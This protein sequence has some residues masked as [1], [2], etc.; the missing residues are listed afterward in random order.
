MAVG[1][2]LHPIANELWDHVQ[3]IPHW[4]K[5]FE[6]AV[7][8]AQDSGIAEMQVVQ[9]LNEYHEK[10]NQW[11]Y[12]VPKENE[13]GRDIYNRICQSYYIMKQPTVKPLQ[14]LI[15]PAASNISSSWITDLL[16]PTLNKLMLDWIPRIHRRHRNLLETPP[17]PLHY[18]RNTSSSKAAGEIPATRSKALLREE[19]GKVTYTL[20]IVNAVP[21]P[22]TGGVKSLV[23][24]R[25]M[26]AAA[27]QF[28]AP[29]T[30]G[31]QFG[32]IR[33]MAVLETA[34]GLVALLPMNMT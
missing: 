14:D 32:Q 3:K 17:D 28:D 8:A 9:S 11:L 15:E 13:E 6:G 30:L 25:T 4:N 12:W 20:C 26:N 5:R 22:G 18:E 29:D 34:V 33:G 10:V 23:P 7:K 24:Y 27:K 1:K 19:H 31:Y 16:R 21:M 2:P